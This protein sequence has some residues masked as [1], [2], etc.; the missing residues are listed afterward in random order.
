MDKPGLDGPP[1]IE[2]LEK[3]LSELA[4]RVQRLEVRLAALE[5]SPAAAPPEAAPQA[6][7]ERAVPEILLGVA[8]GWK[9]TR[10][11]LSFVGRLFVVLGGAFLLRALTDAGTLSAGL[12]VSA[13]L[14]YGLFWVFAAGR[15]VSQSRFWSGAFHGFAAALIAYPLV[16]EAV[17]RF[18]ILSPPWD[19][20]LLAAIAAVFFIVAHRTRYEMLAW[21]AVGGSCLSALALL[22]ATEHYVPRTVFLIALGVVTLWLGYELDWRGLRWPAALAANFAVFG[23]IL[24]A[25]AA[26][27]KETPAAAL[28]VQLL[29]L[30]SYFVSVAVRTLV[31]ARDVIAFEVVQIVFSFLLGFAG[32]VY[33]TQATGVG[34]FVLGFA[35]LGLGVACYAVAFAFL[36]SRI[37]RGKNFYFYTSLALLFV[38]TG[39]GLLWTGAPRAL[40]WSALALLT[41]WLGWRFDR[42]A[43]TVHATLSLLAAAVGA[44][45]PA[46]IARTFTGPP[47]SGGAPPDP[48]QLL[49]M[50]ACAGCAFFPLLQ[51]SER[52]KLG[53]R[54]HGL[55]GI[56]LLVASVGSLGVALA[57]RFLGGLPQGGVDPGW[58]ATIRTVLPALAAMLLAWIGRRKR[59]LEWGWLTYPIL[60]ATGLKML[61]EDLSRSRPATLFAALA[62]Y[63][64]A[65]IVSARL[66]RTGPESGR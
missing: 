31:R 58:L 44:G 61:V 46:F 28:T 18:R 64:L 11:L 51:P 26:S 39:S 24:R 7:P 56:V 12:G 30:T 38:L 52:R 59:F 55:V 10:G 40:A 23:L 45:L 41:G 60:V 21:L 54:L 66:R 16:W 14:A 49:V 19:V 22:A 33:T 47:E 48:A 29:L 50:A 36:D 35:G 57:G 63:G 13:G 34:R 6:G 43:L 5:G 9:D 2:R 8:A 42:M 1:I 17:T 27:P 65:L 4:R 25:L 32:A 15:A 37:G 62:V 20:W 53:T 3:E